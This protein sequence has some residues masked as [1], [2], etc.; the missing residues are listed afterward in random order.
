MMTQRYDVVEKTSL[1]F[2]CSVHCEPGPL[3]NDGDPEV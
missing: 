1:L 3:E 2:G